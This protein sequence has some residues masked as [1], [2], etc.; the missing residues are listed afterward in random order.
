MIKHN[1]NKQ[2]LKKK[3]SINWHKVLGLLNNVK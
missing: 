2:F 1:K 3:K